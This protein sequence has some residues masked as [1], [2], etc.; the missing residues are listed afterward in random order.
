MFHADD[1]RVSYDDEDEDESLGV[2]IDRLYDTHKDYNDDV[3]DIVNR[4]MWI[5]RDIELLRGPLI[6]PTEEELVGLRILE[7][8]KNKFEKYKLEQADKK[9]QTE[10]S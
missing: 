2:L 9:W 10:G 3:L 7:D 5:K 1:Q 6:P 4:V 8:E